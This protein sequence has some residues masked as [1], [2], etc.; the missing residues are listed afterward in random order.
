MF[1]KNALPA[2][3]ARKFKPCAALEGGERG[4]LPDKIADPVMKM[5]AG[6]VIY[7]EHLDGLT[8]VNLGQADRVE[9]ADNPKLRLFLQQ[10]QQR[11]IGVFVRVLKDS[12]AQ[13]WFDAMP[14]K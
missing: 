11:R 13:D 5:I 2:G 9:I 3:T 8:L 4:K 7:P 10:I 6:E 1:F 12:A 14:D